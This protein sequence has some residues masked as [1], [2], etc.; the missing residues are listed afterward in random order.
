[1]WIVSHG[2][3]SLIHSR[4]LMPGGEDDIVEILKETGK[5]VIDGER[6]ER[7]LARKGGR[8]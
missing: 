6:K 4:A 3:A 8:R 5:S 1:M 7:S 2:L